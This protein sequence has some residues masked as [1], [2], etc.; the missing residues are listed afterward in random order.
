MLFTYQIVSDRNSKLRNAAKLSC[1]FW[2]K[3][4]IPEAAIVVRLS[5]FTQFGNTIARAYQPYYRDGVKYG[6]VEFNT[7]F[8]DDFSQYEIVGTLIHEIG[9]TLGIGWDKW[10]NLF[11]ANTGEFTQ[12]ATDAVPELKDMRVETNYGPGTTLVHW[13]EEKFDKELMTGIKDDNEH[14]LPVTIDVMPLLGHQIKEK[15]EEPR[16][17]ASII[18]ELS[19]VVFSRS[20]EATDINRDV[21]IKTDVWEEIYSH[22]KTPLA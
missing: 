1:N 4:L 2:N 19:E 18:D 8:L 17:L 12:N 21:Y 22:Q 15:L 5:V 6:V 16:K 10:M 20:A 7:R 14:V 9:H 11:D 3:Y 13:D